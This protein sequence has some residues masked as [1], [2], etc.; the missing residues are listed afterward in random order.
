MNVTSIAALNGKRNHTGYGAAKGGIIAASKSL[1]DERP[2]KLLDILLK[3]P[4][5]F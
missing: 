4:E 2:I 5:N 1:A 3:N